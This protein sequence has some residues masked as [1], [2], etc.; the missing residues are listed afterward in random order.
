MG[1]LTGRDWGRLRAVKLL[2][3]LSLGLVLVA[4]SPWLAML[5]HVFPG[6]F[7]LSIVGVLWLLAWLLP[8]PR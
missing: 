3:V 7:V 6:L 5:F 8:K 1:L 4:A 2:P